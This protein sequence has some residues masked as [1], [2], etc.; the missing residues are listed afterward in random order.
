MT[1]RKLIKQLKL[2]RAN[3]IILFLGPEG[4]CE[5]LGGLYYNECSD[6]LFF[7]SKKDITITVSELISLLQQ[8]GD[9][10]ETYLEWL[11]R[12]SQ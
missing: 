4:K 6:R 9:G 7:G 1:I 5:N 2:H 12:K 8:Y 3:K 11:S 10:I